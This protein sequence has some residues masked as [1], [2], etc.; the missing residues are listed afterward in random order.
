LEELSV[1]VMTIHQEPVSLFLAYV[2][3]DV[4]WLEQLETHLSVLQD[5]GRI[6]LWHKRQIRAGMNWKNEVDQQIEQASLVLLLVS[7]DFLASDYG[8]QVEVKRA[9]VRQEV[10]LAQVIPIIVRPC[11]W[12]STGLGDLQ[13]LPRDGKPLSMWRH[14]DEALLR[15]AEGVK[16][17]LEERQKTEQPQGGERPERQQSG[18]TKERRDP[19]PLVW[20]V[21][22]RYTP[23]FTG[24]EGV[25]A[26]L[27]TNFTST[28]S[29]GIVPV[30]ALTGLGGL[31]KTQT[32]VA[33]AFRY[34]KEYQA[35]LWIKAETEGDLVASFTT[36]AK[37]LEL[38]G[39]NV[40]ERESVLEGIER[41]LS[42]TSDWLLIIDNA[43][44]LKM[45]EPF[46]P[47]GTQGGHL[48]LTSRA[49]ATDGLAQS[50]ALV[51]LTPEEGALCLLRRANYIGWNADLGA[52]SL[53]VA[54]RKAALDLAELMGGLP[55][56]LEQAGAYIETTG[57]GVAGYLK[58]YE[59]Y[60]PEIQRN[61]YG[62]ILY[63]RSA[64]AFAWNL[65]CEVVQQESPAAIELLYLCAYLS[66]DAIPYELFPKD[67][68]V[69]GP[70]LGPVAAHP[71]AL[72]QALA[73]LRRHSLIKNEVDREAD[74][75]RIFI[76]RVLQ[77]ILRDGM[78]PKTQR[79][80]AERAV[81][82][83]ALALP[84]V[85]WPIMQAHVQA[86]L[87]LI[88][89]WNMHFREADLIRQWV[90]ATEHI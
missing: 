72:D 63:Y 13:P 69:L 75:S 89:Q 86:C 2:E 77:E 7:T 79:K 87:P 29:A 24:R 22:Y 74:V 37:L 56:A 59:Q 50:L 21:P 38:P 73:L 82:V 78:D 65:S 88:A 1:F 6:S 44:N 90:A 71:P 70:T 51:P 19:F 33:Y 54:A 85:E 42:H 15:V 40:K 80:W 67:P 45:I 36:M 32:A 20:H 3:E 62:D 34:R 17:V 10:G 4:Y 23:F 55:L 31:G 83:V 53:S 60:R 49:T 26:D 27:F 30:Q 14:R 25:F 5:S 68:R 46:L 12:K 11:D 41:W 18:R 52:P 66:P 35:V 48:L 58:L 28:P 76:H 43:D 39:V 84:L 8:S 81:H 64:V 61:Q 16:Q 47:M 57:R 9:M